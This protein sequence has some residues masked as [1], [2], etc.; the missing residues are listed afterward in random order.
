MVTLHA[1]GLG[2]EVSLSRPSGTVGALCYP[3]PPASDLRI[4]ADVESMFTRYMGYLQDRE[5]L[6]G[7]AYFCLTVL[8]Y[9]FRGTDG[10]KTKGAAREYQVSKK[11]L[12]TIRRLSSERGGSQARKAEGKDRELTDQEHRFLKEATVTIIERAAHKNHS[13]L[14][15]ITKSDLPQL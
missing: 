10:G 15:K 4:T 11:V 14:P 5:P 8:E 1:Q 6:A 9:P 7:M 2:V 3:H 13:T 12:N